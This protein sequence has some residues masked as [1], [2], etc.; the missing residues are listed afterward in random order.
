MNELDI[1][2]GVLVNLLFLLGF[3]TLCA[4]LREGAERHRRAVSA[5]RTGLLFGAM[6]VVTMLVPSISTVDLIFD[7]R[8]AV[9]G[10][11]GLIGGPLTALISLPLP[12]LYR[13]GIG[14]FGV[15]PGLCELVLPG[16]LGAACHVVLARRGAAL[17]LPR[18]LAASVGVG[19]IPHLLIF[20]SIMTFAP[21]YAANIE[22][23]NLLIIVGGTVVAMALLSALIVL[24]KNH[25]LAMSNLADAE[26]RMLHSQ[27]MAAIGQFARRVAHDIVNTLTV[28][29]GNAEFAKQMAPENATVQALMDEIISET[30]S[31]SNRSCDLLAF[32]QP[33]SGNALTLD[34][35]RLVSGIRP[36]L[37]SALGSEVEVVV[38]VDPDA[39]LVKVDPARIEQALIHLAV[40]GAEAMSKRGQLTLR[41]ARADLSDQ[42]RQRLE[43][44][45]LPRDR[46]ACDFVLI[47]VTDTGCGM[48]SE[49]L[50]HIFE[51]FYSTKTARSNAGLGLATVYNIVKLHNGHIDVQSQPGHGTT[52]LIYLP[53]CPPT[54]PH[55]PISS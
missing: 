6:A 32:A 1:V 44:G 7:T 42:E 21:Q 12:I 24:E 5:W 33:E 13:I 49:Q 8:A 10:T 16:L 40:N 37:A 50:S 36:M 52:F 35:G 34:S 27:K 4:L 28:V 3:V 2:K 20:A 31:M 18:I 48:T 47:T 45:T 26:R 54:D 23:G 39:G 14:G 51:P 17:T 46:H 29:N 30:G 55:P 11:A 43:A 25:S 19:T 9:I 15:I 38:E 22:T 53:A 41:A